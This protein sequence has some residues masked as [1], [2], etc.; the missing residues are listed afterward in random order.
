MPS[1][2]QWQTRPRVIPFWASLLANVGWFCLTM[3]QRTFTCVHPT[4]VLNGVVLFGSALP[5]F[6]PCSRRLITSR[7]P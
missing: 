4:R 2:F 7:P 3:P 1:G 5:P 6:L